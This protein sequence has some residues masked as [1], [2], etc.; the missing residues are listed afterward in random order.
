MLCYYFLR[1][2]YSGMCN[3]NSDFAKSAIFVKIGVISASRPPMSL[4]YTVQLRVQE[5]S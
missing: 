1:L 4:P 3:R 2:S 5:M